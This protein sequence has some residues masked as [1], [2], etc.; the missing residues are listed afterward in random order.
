MYIKY[1]NN[2]PKL[3]ISAEVVVAVINFG[4]S[5]SNSGAI[6]GDVLICLILTDTEA[7]FLIPSRP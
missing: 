2:I 6:K 7:F 5:V 3:Y 1:H 4:F